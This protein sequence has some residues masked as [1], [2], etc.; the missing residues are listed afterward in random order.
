MSEVK[1]RNP[2]HNLDYFARIGLTFT[3][4]MPGGFYFNH[5]CGFS[6]IG[7]SV[8]IQLTQEWSMS[9]EAFWLPVSFAGD[10]L[11]TIPFRF[12]FLQEISFSIISSLLLQF[13]RFI[14]LFWYI[15]SLSLHFVSFKFQIKCLPMYPIFPCKYGHS[16][17]FL[18]KFV[19]KKE[20]RKGLFRD[21]EITKS[22]PA[23]ENRIVFFYLK[24]FMI[25]VDIFF[26]KNMY[27]WMIWYK[28]F[29]I[30]WCF[31]FYC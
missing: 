8:H 19:W 3:T 20:F 25:P 7:I 16:L 1:I 23:Y 22:K 9:G 27:I 28:S 5:C 29:L 14:S 18:F 11:T 10:L 2:V 31:I 4:W 13:G 12:T 26:T 30:E 15:S 6:H 21:L 17:L 24:H